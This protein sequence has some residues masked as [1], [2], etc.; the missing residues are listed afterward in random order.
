VPGPAVEPTILHAAVYD[1]QTSDDVAAFLTG[2]ASLRLNLSANTRRL[3]CAVCEGP[4]GGRDPRTSVVLIRD[5]ETQLTAV[6]LAHHGCAP[7]EMR[8]ETICNDRRPGS[9]PGQDWNLM[10]RR[11][12]RVRAVL[13]WESRPSFDGRP[14]GDCLAWGVDPFA[15]MLRRAGFVPATAPIGYVRPPMSCRLV[16]LRAGRH[17][18]LLRDGRRW[19]EFSGA[20]ASRGARPWLDEA[21]QSRRALLLFGPGLGGDALEAEGVGA[22]LGSGTT[23]CATVRVQSL[24]GV[25]RRHSARSRPFVLTPRAHLDTCRARG[26]DLS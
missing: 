25:D 13:A 5:A 18:V 20:A 14:G 23:L 15:R 10:R 19:V 12:P 7:S 8:H 6:R 22:A 9:L 11:H 24:M 1:L 17:L 21:R 26:H 3:R 16:L 4:L 2:D